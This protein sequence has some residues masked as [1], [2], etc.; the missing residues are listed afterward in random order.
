MSERRAEGTGR[1]GRTQ[2]KE[3]V[4]F[5]FDCQDEFGF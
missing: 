3:I 5:A 2:E 4:Y 1:D